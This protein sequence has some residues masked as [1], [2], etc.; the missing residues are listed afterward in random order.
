MAN[1][2]MGQ[3]YIS[4]H[5]APGDSSDA[6]YVSVSPLKQLR[7]SILNLVL[8]VSQLCHSNTKFST[9]FSR[10]DPREHSKHGARVALVNSDP[11]LL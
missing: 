10:A 1:A 9:K 3:I 7:T 11:I 6:A 4:R 8:C 2:A 5:A